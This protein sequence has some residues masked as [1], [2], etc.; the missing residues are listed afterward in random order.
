MVS[1]IESI[2][3]IQIQCF[4]ETNALYTMLTLVSLVAYITIY[5]VMLNLY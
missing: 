4:S 3:S 5:Y 1:T 2:T